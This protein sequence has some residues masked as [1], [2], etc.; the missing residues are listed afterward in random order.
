MKRVSSQ[1]ERAIIHRMLPQTLKII[2]S[3]LNKIALWAAKLNGGSTPQDGY[4]TI[5]TLLLVDATSAAALYP[6][7]PKHP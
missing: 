6:L 3:T 2:T 1:P 7:I 4:T 5:A